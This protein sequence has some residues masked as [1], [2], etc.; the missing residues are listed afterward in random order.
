MKGPGANAVKPHSLGQQPLF[1]RHLVT[2]AAIVGAHFEVNFVF[3][4]VSVV[5]LVSL[6]VGHEVETPRRVSKIGF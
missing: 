2:C 4:E 1:G 6:H 5:V 3:Q